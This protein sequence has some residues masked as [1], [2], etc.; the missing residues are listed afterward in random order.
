MIIAL[1]ENEKLTEETKLWLDALKTFEAR[2]APGYI[3]GFVWSFVQEAKD[4]MHCSVAHRRE[5]KNF[6]E[7]PEV[8]SCLMHRRPHR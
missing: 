1:K 7:C 8:T 4:H 5:K 6:T 3:Q 2:A